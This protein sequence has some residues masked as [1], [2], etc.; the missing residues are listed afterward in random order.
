MS[1]SGPADTH[2]PPP[3]PISARHPIDIVLLMKAPEA[4]FCAAAL[5]RANRTLSITHAGTH[6]DIGN[7]L[8][9]LSGR[10]RLIGFSTAI[11]VAKEYL[12]HFPGGAYNFH[13]GPP[14][15]PGNRPSAF[16]C[17]A[18]A[19]QFGVT[20]HRMIARVDEGEILDCERFPSMHF[21]TAADIAIFAYQ[22]LARLF[23]ANTVALA[24]LSRPLIGNGEKWSGPKT[25]QS[26]FDAMREVPG[27]IAPAELDRRIRAFNWV[28]TRIAP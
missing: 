25:T 18:R 6:V 22:R 19:S 5:H 11:V 3:D 17:Y 8:P 15:Y 10:A 9:L 20:F 2:S 14:E 28:Y 7:A 1:G 23:L 12:T 16:A 4:A 13:P 24:T 27:D 21:D 26:Q